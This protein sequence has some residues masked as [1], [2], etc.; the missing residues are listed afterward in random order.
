ML[1]VRVRTVSAVDAV[2]DALA[3]DIF[4]QTYLPGTRI[5]E[6]DLADRYGVSRNTI[7]EAIAYL[8]GNGILV[9]TA[10]RGIYV[11]KLTSGDVREI[12]R[13][14]KLFEIEAIHML[15]ARSGLPPALLDAQRRIEVIDVYRNWDEYVDADTN[16]HLALVETAGS[17]RL[18]RLYKAIVA[19]VK[20][21][22][23][24]SMV[25]I[26]RRDED[27]DGQ[28][29]STD[30]HLAIIKALKEND[31]PS[32]ERALCAHLD[33][34]VKRFNAMFERTEPR[35]AAPAQG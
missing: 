33:D 21:C 20:L 15:A 26:D 6:V 24:Q 23:S 2:A 29:E 8:I 25:L 7:R 28:S 16:F 34:A 22:I 31:A 30:G 14:R 13:L 4:S 17:A 12:F 19:E 18:M 27:I 9:K 5:K 11:K 3:Q 10:N 35:I 1:D 32:A